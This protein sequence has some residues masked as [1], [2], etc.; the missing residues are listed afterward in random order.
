V[1][2]LGVFDTVSA[3]GAK[4]M[5]AATVLQN[6]RVLGVTTTKNLRGKGVLT[7]ELNPMEAEYAFLALRQADLGVA[8]RAPDDVES[9][10]ME[11]AA[12]R[13]LFR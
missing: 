9:H 2:V 3:S 13:R 5:F 12:F 10:P 1:D 11:M 4:E 8:V 7:L 6:I